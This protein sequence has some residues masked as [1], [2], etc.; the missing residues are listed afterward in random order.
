MAALFIAAALDA[1]FLPFPVTTMFVVFS[2][3]RPNLSAQY[4]VTAVAGTMTGAAAGYLSGRYMWIT[5]TGSF[6]TLA[7]LFFEKV[8]GFSVEGYERVTLLYEQWDVGVIIG[9]SATAIPFGLIS[10]SAGIFSL[11]PL[12]FFLSALIGQAAKYMVVA[13]LSDPEFIFINGNHDIVNP[14]GKPSHQITNSQGQ[15]IHI[16]HGHQADWLN[17]SRAGRAIGQ[18]VLK[19]LK[20]FSHLPPVLNFYFRMVA[21]EEQLNRIPKRFNTVKYMIY[22][23]KLLR[24]YDVVILGHT[25]KLESHHTY[26]LNRKKRYLNCGS[27]SF[28]RF[29]G[30]IL[31]TETL[32]YEFLKSETNG[33][34]VYSEPDLSFLQAVTI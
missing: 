7:S 26:Y 24:R 1:S 5:P 16:E 27:C 17:G 22:A 15:V 8:P 4:A 11:P 32:R 25:H 34:N 19:L 30:I 21:F 2:L 3:T 13:Y 31:N 12:A 9:A 23:L 14:Y 33:L 29:E 10:I 18:S 6:T 20:R 28:G